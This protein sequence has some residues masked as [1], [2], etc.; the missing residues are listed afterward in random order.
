MN[1]AHKLASS[2]EIWDMVCK[3]E[4]P[5]DIEAHYK[6]LLYYMDVLDITGAN[7]YDPPVAARHTIAYL[8]MAVPSLLYIEPGRTRELAFYHHLIYKNI[9]SPHLLKRQNEHNSDNILLLEKAMVAGL[10]RMISGRETYG[11]DFHSYAQQIEKRILKNK[12]SAQSI[13]AIETIPGRYE[14]Y[15]NFMALMVFALHDKLYDSDYSRVKAGVLEFLHENLRNEE[16][17]LYYEYLHTGE[18]GIPKQPFHREL[19]WHTTGLKAGTNGL[20]LSLLHYFE[21]QNAKDAWENYKA[22]FTDEL[23]ELDKD[24]LSEAG[25]SYHTQLG[26]G[27]EALCAALLAAREMDDR[28]F[29]DRIY[30]HLLEI[31]RCYLAE[32]H[33]FFPEL[34][35][36]EH[37]IGCFLTFAKTHVGWDKLLGH[38]WQK[39]YI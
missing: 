28:V 18:A 9:L 10:Y 20:I 38:D 3:R 25:L 14:A 39:G 33:I 35:E 21:P 7:T 26:P 29:F 17:G 2:A 11:D 13:C 27:S 5:D 32:A 8:A 37:L 15:P 31:S 12:N 1:R 6:M 16:T 30:R 34:G 19:Y 23:L 36:Y 24:G 22:F 4:Y